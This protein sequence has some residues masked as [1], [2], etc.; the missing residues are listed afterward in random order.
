MLE[1]NKTKHTRINKFGKSPRDMQLRQSNVDES[2]V[3]TL[4]SRILDLKKEV[5][6]LKNTGSIN[7]DEFNDAVILAVEKEVYSINKD[8]DL[9]VSKLTSELDLL[10]SEIVFL[11]DVIKQKDAI[12]NGIHNNS[13]MNTKSGLSSESERPEMEDAVIDPS[14]DVK[15]ESHINI[16]S[17]KESI[18]MGNKLTKLKGILSN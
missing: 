12:I 14:D 7:D 15:L 18:D 1:Y 2:V 4:M 9:K 17:T 10:K 13:T 8:Y 5:D 16:E 6:T 11:K 3:S